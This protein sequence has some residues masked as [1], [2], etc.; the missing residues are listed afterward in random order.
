MERKRP[1]IVTILALLPA[2]PILAGIAIVSGEGPAAPVLKPAPAAQPPVAPV[3]P[4]AP[5]WPLVA[6]LRKPTELLG[7][8]GGKPLGRLGLKTAFGSQQY[9]LV[10]RASG[11]W[12]GVLSEI[13]GNGRVGWI[14][15][16]T[17]TISH[18]TYEVDVSIHQHTVTVKNEN[19]V[20]GRF[21]AAVGAAASPTPTGRFAITDRIY[22]GNP[23]GPYGCCV[24]ATTAVSPHPIE[25][26]AGGNRVAIHSTTDVASIGHSVSHGCVR[27]SIKNGFYLMSHVPLGTPTVIT[28]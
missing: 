5:Q 22:T 10:A 17:A 6:H 27:V 18:V 20:L 11:H 25:N 7:T 14:P 24:L 4:A 23:A 26:W 16:S 9:L 15:A 19:A 28:A 12:L 8:P 1:F 21:K 13:A 3:A 2:A